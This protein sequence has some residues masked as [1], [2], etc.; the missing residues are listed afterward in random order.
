M[1]RDGFS[2]KRG[3]IRNHAVSG[4]RRRIGQQHLLAAVAAKVLTLDA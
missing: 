4:Q 1:P 2:R 3:Q